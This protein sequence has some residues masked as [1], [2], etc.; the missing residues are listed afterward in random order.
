[1]E[2]EGNCRSCIDVAVVG[3]LELV[4]FELNTDVIAFGNIGYV[5]CNVQSNV[6]RR[7]LYSTLHRL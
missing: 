6:V 4:G 1:M 3:R 5:R 7:D 2:A